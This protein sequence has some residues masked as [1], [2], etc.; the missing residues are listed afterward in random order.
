MFSFQRRSTRDFQDRVTRKLDL[1]L[2]LIPKVNLMPM[3][4]LQLDRDLIAR[5][6]DRARADDTTLDAVLL[7]YLTTYAEH[8]SP[9]AA[10]ARAVNAQRTG[11]ER[12]AA[13]RHAVSARWSKRTNN[14]RSK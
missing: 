3:Y 6:K 12:S 8:G 9:Q 10:G 14:R 2:T 7:R 5:A 1:L 4:A 11:S 13:A